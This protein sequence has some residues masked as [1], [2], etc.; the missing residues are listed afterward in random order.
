MLGIYVV[1]AWLVYEVV[2]ALYEG[3][4]LP[5]WVP[6]TAITILLLGLPLVLATAFVQEGPPKLGGEAGADD[7]AR[8]REAEAGDTPLTEQPAAAA[9]SAGTDAGPDLGARPDPAASSFFTW[10]RTVT[11]VVL[12]FA[13]LG[14]A[15]SGFMGMRALGVGPAA[16]LLTRGEL[17]THATIVLA[18][19]ENATS[20]SLL[21]GAVREA[22]RMD[23]TESP[24]ISLASPTEVA[25]VMGWM[26][27]ETT[28]PLTADM[29]REIAVRQG[30][31]AVLAGRVS[32]IGNRYAITAEL[33]TADSGRVLAGFR[34]TATR[35]GVVRALDRISSEI[36]KEVGESLRSIR[37]GRPLPE[38]T[39]ASLDALRA[40][41]AGRTEEAVA[42]DSTFARAW[43]NLAIRYGRTGYHRAREVDAARRAYRLRERLNPVERGHVVAVYHLN[44]TGDWAVAADAYGGV[45]AIH[46]NDHQAVTNRGVALTMMRDYPRAQAAHERSV[47]VNPRSALSRFNLAGILYAQGQV[48]SAWAV[49]DRPDSMLTYPM[50]TERIRAELALN[51]GDFERA[52]RQL[53]SIRAVTPGS[54]TM[55]NYQATVIEA[56]LDAIQGQIRNAVRHSW[57]LGEGARRVG[58]L[59]LWAAHAAEAVLILAHAG[60][61]A[62]E[63]LDTLDAIRAELDLERTAP[64]ANPYGILAEAYA[65]IG[66]VEAAEA[67]LAGFDAV[68]AEIGTSV[69]DANRFRIARARGILALRAGDPERALD[70]FHAGDVPCTTGEW[71]LPDLCFAALVGLAHEEAGR[72]DSAIAAYERYLAVRT[73]RRHTI[74]ALHLAT[75]LEHL[76]ALYEA[77]G[78]R[79]RAAGYY[80]RFIE[81]WKDADPELQPRVQAARRALGRLAS[82]G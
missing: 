39:T 28:A 71:T 59:P 11:A 49:L 30:W 64:L 32:E 10:R 35:E 2:V 70:A 38:A 37:D 5:V 31:P 34:E 13:G 62:T 79:E 36:R 25:E 55:A 80:A 27:Q 40:F 66:R 29:A 18:D 47:E 45:L 48:D 78:D 54:I 68:D 73:N 44:V 3:L 23:L 33:V 60:L 56:D 42:I 24:V 8:A 51:E 57:L 43:M 22:L 20:D 65:A 26:Q 19:F 12:G 50:W 67:Q 9:L 75:V 63:A 7:A 53:D 46:P 16:T 81:L 74:D 15:A 1:A 17:E 21:A 4:G 14:L 6:P 52:R 72:P 61:D 58:L 76:G 69:T 41:A 82:E 77:R